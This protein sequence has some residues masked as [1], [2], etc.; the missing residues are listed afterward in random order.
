MILKIL[1]VHKC[2]WWAIENKYVLV[3]KLFEFAVELTLWAP[4]P[5]NGQTHAGKLF[6]CVWTCDIGA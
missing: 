6:E 3:Y 1:Y 5:K 4:T 2:I